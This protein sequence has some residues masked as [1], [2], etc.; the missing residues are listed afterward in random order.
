MLALVGIDMAPLDEHTRCALYC[1]CTKLRPLNIK[2]S[3]PP[4][5]KI[6]IRRKESE[7]AHVFAVVIFGITCSFVN[8][9]WK[10]VFVAHRE[11]VR[12]VL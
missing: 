4:P 8:L 3:P 7:D 12:R 1:R 10:T 11:E 2:H 5:Q 6:K 9:L